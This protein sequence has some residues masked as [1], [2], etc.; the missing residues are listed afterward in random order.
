[1]E[2]AEIAGHHLLALAYAGLGRKD[3]AI[4]AART[5]VELNANDAIKLPMAQIAQ[6][7]V[8]AQFGERDAAIAALPQLLETPAGL[9]PPLLAFD[10]MWDPLRGDPRFQKLAAGSPP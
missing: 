10:P 7:Q 8:Y 4:A 2:H 5:G 6:A 1:M 9:T 3:Q